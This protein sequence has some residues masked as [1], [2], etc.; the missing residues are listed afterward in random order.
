MVNGLGSLEENM[1][2]TI[3]NF[4]CRLSIYDHPATQLSS[5]IQAT[6]LQLA[7]NQEIGEVIQ[8]M[9]FEIDQQLKQEYHEELKQDQAKDETRMIIDP[10]LEL[11]EEVVCLELYNRIFEQSLLEYQQLTEKIA[12]LNLLDLSLDHLGLDLER[13]EMDD[14]DGIITIRNGLDEIIKTAS[15]VM[16][17]LQMVIVA[18]YTYK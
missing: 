1:L 3:Q 6:S 10:S 4:I 12:Q 15:I 5:S 2:N 13:R 7:T 9:Y 8:E 14:P 17:Q 11:I 18:T 16:I